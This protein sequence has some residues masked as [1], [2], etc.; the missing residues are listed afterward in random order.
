MQRR[1]AI[2]VE[3]ILFDLDG[4]LVDTRPGIGYALREAIAVVMPHKKVD[5][6]DLRSIIGPPIRDVLKKAIPDIDNA[7]LDELE[8]QFR[9]TY[10]S[11]GW[12]QCSAYDGVVD[13]MSR[14]ARQ[15]I[16]CFVVTN[17]RI[18]P[19]LKILER[20]QLKVYFDEVVSW[21][22]G[23][24]PYASKVEMVGYVIHKYHLKSKTMLLVGDSSEEAQA[25]KANGARFA[26]VAYGYGNVHTRSEWQKDYILDKFSDLLGIVSSTRS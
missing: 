18:E 2:L 1:L 21:D 4:T 25:A 24:R 14:I 7:T 16:E 3:S 5:I 6:P 13:T 10:D 9:S 17:K 11:I 20:L 23:A 19:T 12:Q 26:A 8:R 22:S 15:K